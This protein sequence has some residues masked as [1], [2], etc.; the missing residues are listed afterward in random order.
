MRMRR[1]G[2]VS[3]GMALFPR[4]SRVF[5][6][7]APYITE[8]LTTQARM[9]FSVVCLL[10]SYAAVLSVVTQ[11]SSPQR[12]ASIRTACLSLCVCGKSKQPVM[13]QQIDSDVT[14][15]V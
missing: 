12:A 5:Q 4:S 6:H 10:V 8:A 14:L 3:T 13:Y 1:F 7:R 9:A 11:R 15:C 2:L